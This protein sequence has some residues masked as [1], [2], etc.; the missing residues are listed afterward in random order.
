AMKSRAARR[1]PAPVNKLLGRGR[2]IGNMSVRKDLK[3]KKPYAGEIG[4]VSEYVLASANARGAQVV[5]YDEVRDCDV[6]RPYG[7]NDLRAV[8]LGTSPV[9]RV[10]SPDQREAEIAARNASKWAARREST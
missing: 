5:S 10:R 3:G 7:E 8:A 2:I 6:L 4:A 1:V 9:E